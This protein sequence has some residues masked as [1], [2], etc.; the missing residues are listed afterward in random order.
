MRVIPRNDRVPQLVGLLAPAQ[1]DDSKP[2]GFSP[3][4]GLPPQEARSAALE[5]SRR[6]AWPVGALG[7]TARLVHSAH[8]GVALLTLCSSSVYE[9]RFTSGYNSLQLMRL[10]G[11]TRG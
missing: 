7:G 6:T 2:S 4:A 11:C 1:E 10:G 3:H 8:A 9:D 5:D